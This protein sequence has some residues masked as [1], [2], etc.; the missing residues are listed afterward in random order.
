V[1]SDPGTAEGR[2]ARALQNA[3]VLADS[4][5]DHAQAAKILDGALRGADGDA[6]AAVL[7][8]ALTYRAELARELGS[9]DTDLAVAL[10]ARDRAQAEEL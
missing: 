10:A 4:H 5:G 2:L 6:D 3:V 9:I 8:E 1:T 7:A